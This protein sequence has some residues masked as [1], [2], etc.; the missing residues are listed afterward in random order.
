VERACAWEE[1]STDLRF[2]VTLLLM[3][4]S[5]TVP[6]Y[7]S[8]TSNSRSHVRLYFFSDGDVPDDLPVIEF[9]SLFLPFGSKPCLS[10]NEMRSQ[11]VQVAVVR[12]V[13][14][15][16]VEVEVVGDTGDGDV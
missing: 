9:V 3:F 5:D 16:V 13:W 12:R 11:G 2:G 4:K 14:F 6:S 1:R 8:S 15:E 7:P 10:F